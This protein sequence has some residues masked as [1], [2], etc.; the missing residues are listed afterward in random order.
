MGVHRDDDPSN[1]TEAIDPE[2]RQYTKADNIGPGVWFMFHL[3]S[4]CVSYGSRVECN[5]ED[6]FR[7][8]AEQCA[9][10]AGFVYVG[11]PSVIELCAGACDSLFDHG[12]ATL[13]EIV[14]EHRC[15]VAGVIAVTRRRSKMTNC[16]RGLPRSCRET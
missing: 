2:L 13:V 16:G 4:Y 3:L 5:K 9:D 10:E 8:L 14:N 11:Y 6:L 12:V 7:G 1:G 15:D